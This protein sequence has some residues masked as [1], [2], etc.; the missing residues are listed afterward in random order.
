MKVFSNVFGAKK[1]SL[2]EPQN[3]TAEFL[4]HQIVSDKV[5]TIDSQ[6]S[7]DFNAVINRE[8]PRRH[9]RVLPHSKSR[10]LKAVFS[11][12]SKRRKKHTYFD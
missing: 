8:L 5:G 10:A 7:Y 9:P 4:D 6:A 12:N 3:V 1:F 2:P 11:V